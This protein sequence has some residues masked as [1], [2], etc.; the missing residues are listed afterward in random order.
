MMTQKVFKKH[1]L[2]IILALL[3]ILLFIGIQVWN[4]SAPVP[5]HNW[6]QK[7]LSQ[8]TVADPNNYSFAVMGDNK[9]SRSVFEPLMRDIDRDKEIA[10]AIDDGDLVDGG[11]MRHYRRFLRRVQGNLSIPLLTA[12]GNHDLDKNGSHKNYE[13]IFGPTY[14]SFQVGQGYFI[15][16]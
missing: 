5:T 3:C 15:V 16:L 11:T 12:I 7:E 13:A 9:G 4:S 8:I 14:Y 1:P 2:K 10:F 6:T